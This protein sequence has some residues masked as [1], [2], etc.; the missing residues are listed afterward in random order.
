MRDLY[1]KVTGL[2]S[3][4]DDVEGSQELM[5]EQ[6]GCTAVHGIATKEIEADNTA[7]FWSTTLESRYNGRAVNEA[8]Q[9]VLGDFDVAAHFLHVGNQTNNLG[10]KFL[11]NIPCYLGA[12]TAMT[13]DTRNH[14]KAPS[15]LD[16]SP[17]RLNIFDI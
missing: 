11:I 6:L 9:L 3:W 14:D 10:L 8:L 4:L 12:S 7:E 16:P 15:F 2:L 5:K 1:D 17:A 13:D